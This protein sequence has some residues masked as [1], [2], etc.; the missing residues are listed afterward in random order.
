MPAM[1]I[2]GLAAF[3]TGGL[4]Q[5]Q[6]QPAE[7]RLTA[8]RARAE[9]RVCIWPGYHGL[10]WR[11]PRT[12]ELEGLDVEMA[13]LLAARLRVRPAF[14]EVLTPA[15]PAAVEAGRCDIAMSGVTVTEERATRIAFS[16]PYL[17]TPLVGIANRASTRVREW[18]D[19]DRPGVVVMV[20]EGAPA[21]AIMRESLRRAELSVLPPHRRRE[22]EVQAG[23]ADVS[24]TDVP[25]GTG[26]AMQQDWVRL[27]PAPP[28]FGETLTAYAVPR[29][30]AAWL[31]EVNNF[32]AAVKSDG[33]L[34]RAAD[35]FGL[36][37]LLVY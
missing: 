31:A 9:L 14:M 25:F 27:V 22:A 7:D 13:R 12:G 33:A 23:R 35:R 36:V 21:M 16:K 37:G 17:A 19:I 24:I 18:D 11:N 15:I 8:I 10:S 20:A 4:A 26:L 30:D 6:A 32:L 29:G 28:R 1:I 2:A 34:A 5:A 3:C